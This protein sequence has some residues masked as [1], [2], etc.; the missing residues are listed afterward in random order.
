MAKRTSTPLDDLLVE[1]L[2]APVVAFI[3]VQGFIA[4]FQ[5]LV[6]G[7]KSMLW[8]ARVSHVTVAMAATWVIVRIM[9]SVLD[10]L[11]TGRY[12]GQDRSSRLLPGIRAVVRVLIWG[13]GSVVALN[14]AGYD[15]AALL[16]GIGI[17]GLSMAL[18]AQETVANVF[19]GITNYA[20]MPIKLGDCVRVDGRDG[21]VQEIGIWSTHI[22][23]L[24]G[25]IVVIPNKKFT[26]S[27][28]ENVS[29]ESSRRALVELGLIY[30]TAPAMMERAM[31]VLKEIVM[32]HQDILEER[33]FISF[34]AFKE[35]A[36]NILFIYF[37]PEDA[38]IFEAHS[39]VNLAILRRFTE[40]GLPFAYTTAVE[41]QDQFKPCPSLPSLC[42]ACGLP[43]FFSFKFRF[44][45]REHF[46][47]EHV[48]HVPHLAEH[49]LLPAGQVAGWRFA[50]ESPRGREGSGYQRGLR[51]GELL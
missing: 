37:I 9:L 26:E 48:A 41:L 20:D 32:A 15:V 44:A 33:R 47:V 16:A 12:E 50:V 34:N 3:T 7:P 28:I 10:V 29:D 31:E 46:W 5:Q 36:L 43:R 49:P 11:M 23:A 45:S 25:P 27:T 38:H 19:G 2:R 30:E 4:G 40:E 1:Q 39:R 8:G 14:N 17:G 51:G 6:I 18:A 42:L 13:L 22:Q 35:Y 21:L 24:V